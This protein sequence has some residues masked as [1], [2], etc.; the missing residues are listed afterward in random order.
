ML[1]PAFR[2]RLE[3]IKSYMHAFKRL[4]EYVPKHQQFLS[5]IVGAKDDICF[6]Y[7]FHNFK[8]LSIINMHYFNF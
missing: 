5:I 4:K 7:Y 8:I 1:G 6:S 2:F 3:T